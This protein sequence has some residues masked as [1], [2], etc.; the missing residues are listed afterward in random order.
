M[1]ELVIQQNRAEIAVSTETKE[2]IQSSIAD[3]TLER[4]RRLS[5]QIGAWLG[6]QALND[7]LLATYITELHQQ[8]KSPATIAQVV[9]A[10][11]WLA[12]NHGVE[13]VGEV[14]SKTLAGIR[15]EGKDRGK[16]QVDG[17]EREDM[18]RVVTLA[19]AD[20][21]IGGLRDAAL[22]RLMSDCLLRISEAVAVNVE[23][24]EENSLT[25]QRS[26]TDQ[27]G[28]TATLY[29]GDKTKHLINRYL[30]KADITAGAVFVRFK[31]T[32]SGPQP[33]DQRLT[34]R[35]ARYIIKHR[36]ELA[37]V[38]GKVSGHSLRVGTAVS[39][40]QAGAGISEMQDAGRWESQNMPGH[41]ARVK[42]AEKGAVARYRYGKGK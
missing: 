13:I 28:E 4:D 19:E 5:E 1:N 21:T 3:S 26:K 30:R 35:A 38:E 31:T 42:E 34:D 12:K 15:R 23:D 9:A 41:Y 17:V 14:A 10:A 33:T 32:K 18:L 39:L 37:G 16:G 36:A 8:G 25:V 24:F 7:G 6:G 27:T 40:S 29:I 22:I 2:L 11:K 20:K